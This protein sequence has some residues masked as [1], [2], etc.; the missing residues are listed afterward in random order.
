LSA[1]V[2]LV[3]ERLRE[4]HAALVAAL[5]AELPQ[6]SF[7]PAR[8]GYFLWLRVPGL[9][10]TSPAARAAFGRHGVTVAAGTSFVAGGGALDPREH[11]RLCFAHQRP[12]AL[13]EGV[14]RLATAM[15]DLVP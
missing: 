5:R 9:D 12:D 1:H 2:A 15:H 7:A 13:R 4:R 3:R 11:V 8:G 6:A 10:A 14:A